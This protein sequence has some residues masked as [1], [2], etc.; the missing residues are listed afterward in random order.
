M[1]T[2]VSFVREGEEITINYNSDPD[3]DPPV[4]FEVR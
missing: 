2:R 4:W 3:D 1:K